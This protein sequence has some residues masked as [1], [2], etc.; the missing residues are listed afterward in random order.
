LGLTVAHGIVLHNVSMRIEQ[1]RESGSRRFSISPY[2][3]ELVQGAALPDGTRLELRPIRPE[4]EPALVDFHG[5]LAASDIRMRFFAA[6]SVLSHRRAA[7]LTQID[8]DREMALVAEDEGRPGVLGVVR[9]IADPDNLAAEFALVVRS[10]CKRRGLGRLLLTRLIDIARNRGI[11]TLFGDVLRENA[12][13]LAL[14]RALGFK[15]IAL[16]GSPGIMR[17]TLALP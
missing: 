2:P 13:M 3:G 14:C 4:D 8:Y 1:A 16:A 15:A 11:G 5:H 7:R 9:F 6:I 10:D 17:V 12:P